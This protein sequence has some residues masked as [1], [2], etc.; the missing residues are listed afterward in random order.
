MFVYFIVSKVHL[1]V[2]AP[3]QFC[4]SSFRNPTPPQLLYNGIQFIE[5]LYTKVVYIDCVRR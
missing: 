4:E 5:T 2:S 3:S 1:S